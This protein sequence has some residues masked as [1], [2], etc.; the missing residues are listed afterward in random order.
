M[1]DPHELARDFEQHVTQRGFFSEGDRLL[2]AVSGGLDSL[3]LL[4][5]LRF[6]RGL[7]R[8]HLSVG[9]FDHRMRPESSGDASWVRGVAR[10]WG[11]PCQES[12][13]EATLS[14]EEEAR[15]ARYEFL[16]AE[17]R[18][19][20]ARWIVTAHHADDQAETVL[21]RIVRGTGPGG[22]AG[23]PEQRAPGILRPLL[24]FTRDRIAGYAD[25]VGIQ[26]RLDRSNEDP[27]FA[28][29]VIRNEV[30][31]RLEAAVAPGA[32]SSLVRLSRLA[33]QEERAWQSLLTRL[34]DD[35]ILE[36]SDARI[37]VDRNAWLDYESEVQARALRALSSRLGVRLDEAGTRAAVAFTSA[38][39]SG[40]E[41]WIT[42]L[43]RVQRAFDHLVIELVPERGGDRSLE[44]GEA[45]EGEGELTVGGR[46]WWATWSL[47]GAPEG[48]W[49]E[50]FSLPELDFPVRMR[51]WSPGDRL[52][53]SYGSKKLKKVF[54]EARVPVDERS[55]VPVVVDG[56][57]R[58]LWVP[59]VSR[60]CL[61]IPSEEESS[62]AIALSTSEGR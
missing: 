55:R 51:G 50:R 19:S 23:I 20:G 17:Q 10:A 58:V 40:R 28:R 35:L 42:G 6:S 39:V 59:G 46:D 37:V 60:S 41:H 61:L 33:R 5:L 52:R 30:L 8:L 36:A 11:L 29:N 32:R 22:L 12:V 1:S 49:V 14:G 7:P 56:S 54:G 43:L 44:I 34:L 24:P 16:E 3:A 27:G 4:H 13:A 47:D 45:G 18:A 21:F 15:E 38:G 9:H 53:Y 31:P 48:G 2:V 25:S 57:G 26:P 62:L